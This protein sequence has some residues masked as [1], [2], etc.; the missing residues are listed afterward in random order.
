MHRHD[1]ARTGFTTTANARATTLTLTL[2]ALLT[3]AAVAPRAHALD[4]AHWQQA[5][6]AIERG[7]AYLRSTQNDD[8]SWSP[9]PGPAIT[10]MA[11][12]V[13]LDRPDISAD[14][15]AVDRALDYILTQV[16]DDGSIHSGIL[17]NYN[18]A[19]CLSALSRVNHRPDVARAIAN[20]QDFLR[21]I[22]WHDQPDPA[23]TP[24]DESHPFYGGAGYG[25]HGRPD[26]SNTQ[27]M[28][29]GLYDSGV[30]C[31][32]PA[33]RRALVFIQRCQGIASND[34]FADQI[35]HDGGFIYATSINKDRIGVPESKASP[36][37]IDEGK[38]DR[39]VSGLRT[40]GSMTYAGFKSYLYANLRRDDPRVT[41]AYNWIREH[42]TLDRN[43]GM[44][45]PMKHQGLYYYYMTFA[46]ALDAWGSTT[47]ETADG[48]RRDWANDLI[49]KLAST[50]R[51]DGS[52]VNQAD[53]W[54]EDDPNLVTAYALIALT[55]AIR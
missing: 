22:Q 33:F 48:Q 10:A 16:N 39:P 47:I 49:A 31:E 2:V 12:T 45:E 52:W 46:R 25:K 23:G 13:M 43:P 41:A 18:T 28:L 36:E 38:A 30:D 50:Q 7:I 1:L 14:D 3:T 19:I 5:N 27:I 55:H 40:Y 17:A 15:P 51:D 44:P 6:D 8:G 35:V 42:Y 24:V 29:Q 34:L 20:A 9:Q 11:I 54:M 37:M 21:G 32:G 4:D 53:R 26:L